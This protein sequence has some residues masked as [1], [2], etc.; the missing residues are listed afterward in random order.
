MRRF[1]MAG[2]ALL[3]V[4]MTLPPTPITHAQ[5]RNNLLMCT[6]PD[7]PYAGE[8]IFA[9]YN[10]RALRLVSNDTGAEVLTL[11]T[12]LVTEQFDVRGWSA[13]CRYLIA[14]AGAW[15]QQTTLAYDTTVGQRVGAI[16]TGGQRYDN[17]SRTYAG[18]Y[19]GGLVWSPL[20]PYGVLIESTHGLFFWN[21]ATDNRLHLTPS[22]ISE[23]LAVYR[24]RYPRERYYPWE[25]YI[26]A[27][28]LHWQAPNRL[29]LVPYS[30]TDAVSV[31]DLDSGQQ[32]A[33][34]DLLGQSGPVR[35]TV[36][37]PNILRVY[38]DPTVY[39]RS[40]MLALYRRD[41]GQ[42]WL[43]TGEP[44][45]LGPR[46]TFFSADG[47]YLI[48]VCDDVLVYEMATLVGDGPVAVQQQYDTPYHDG[49][50]IR[51][52]RF[53]DTGFEAIGLENSWYTV[54]EDVLMYLR[55]EW[56]TQREAEIVYFLGSGC[57][58]PSTLRNPVD[59]A[60]LAWACT[61]LED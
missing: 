54:N 39:N 46:N 11:D 27:E 33:R 56:G 12:E 52:L 22:G 45:F 9:R 21:L 25:G 44:L 49:G 29:W 30:D 37:E 5:H 55:W 15:G 18:Q 6:F 35:F 48:L 16:D 51:E 4:L 47:R 59:P 10:N 14:T 53:S 3:L 8:N 19:L 34:Y 42:Q 60:I 26:N 2:L 28:I 17:T 58:D 1:I 20:Y 57:T 38:A 32:V 31:Y 61:L 7:G 13:D 50:D 40:G 43:F 23:G 41:T 36:Q 24:G